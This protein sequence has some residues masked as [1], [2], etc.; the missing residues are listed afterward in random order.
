MEFVCFQVRIGEIKREQVNDRPER[1]LDKQAANFMA[2]ISLTSVKLLN[3]LRYSL[4]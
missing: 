2:G 1:V 4:L 3:F